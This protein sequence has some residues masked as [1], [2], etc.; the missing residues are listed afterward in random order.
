M[1]RPKFGSVPIIP[2]DLDF[3]ETLSSLNATEGVWAKIIRR[4]KNRIKAKGDL[5]KLAKEA[6]FRSVIRWKRR[7]QGIMRLTLRINGKRN[8]FHRCFESQ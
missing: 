6:K 4:V 3:N 5:E 2:N 1:D 7:K 8:G